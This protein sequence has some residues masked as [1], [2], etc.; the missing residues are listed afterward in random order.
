MPPLEYGNLISERLQRWQPMPEQFQRLL[1]LSA[2]RLLDSAIIIEDNFQPFT[3][4][5]DPAREIEIPEFPVVWAIED[6]IER[7]KSVGLGAELRELAGLFGSIMLKLSGSEKQQMDVN[8]WVE[9]GMT[10]AFSMT[11]KGGPALSQ[12][13][14]L[15][16]NESETLKFSVDK[17]WSIGA[18][19]FDFVIIIVATTGSMVPKAMLVPPELTAAL[20]RKPTGIPFF[21]GQL[22]LGACTGEV[23]SDENLALSNGGLIAVKQFLTLCRPLF[24]RSIMSHLTWL[25][26]QGR[27]DFRKEHQESAEY[28]CAVARAIQAKGTFTSHSE[29]EVMA[30]KFSSNSLLLDIVEKNCLLSPLDARDLLSLTKM[31]GSSYRCF[32]EIYSRRRSQRRG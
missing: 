2:L 30:L 6:K 31:E 29:D 27:L 22:Q 13:K 19:D 5:S 9:D 17:I 11:D 4:I 1:N 10:G 3:E 18:E 25:S 15:I 28:L 26:A 7:V 8:A 20:K 14:T 21:D 32:M 12:W 23:Q 16:D 24:V